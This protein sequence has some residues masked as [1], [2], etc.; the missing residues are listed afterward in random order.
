MNAMEL[1]EMIRTAG[2][3]LTLEDGRIDIFCKPEVTAKVKAELAV[4]A[5]GYGNLRAIVEEWASPVSAAEAILQAVKKRPRK[6]KAKESIGA[7]ERGVLEALSAYAKRRGTCSPSLPMLTQDLGLP[8]GEWIRV[9]GALANLEAAG[10][11]TVEKRLNTSNR[12]TLLAKMPV[13]GPCG[14]QVK[15]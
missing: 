3:R 9:R 11:I 4:D 15:L 14:L 8:A 13:D 2:G 1:F 12:Y 7:F 5:N 6:P 10:F